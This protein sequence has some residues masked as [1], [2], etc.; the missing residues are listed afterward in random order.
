MATHRLPPTLSVVFTS[1]VDVCVYCFC[2]E[3]EMVGKEFS[4][5]E[6]QYTFPFLK[7]YHPL[8]ILND[9]DKFIPHRKPDSGEL[10]YCLMTLFS[11]ILSECICL[12]GVC[13]CVLLW[14]HC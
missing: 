7:K 5:P 12:F 14:Q 1:T 9:E 3:F 4:W 6:N 11:D 10:T 8:L 2:I 13:V